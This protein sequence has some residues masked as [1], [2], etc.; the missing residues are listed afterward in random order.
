MTELLKSRDV[1]CE[2]RV[3]GDE[4]TGHVFHVNIK[5]ELATQANNDQCEF[6]K[7]HVG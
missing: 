3:Y 1:E 2:S 6:L 4:T 5:S 7:R